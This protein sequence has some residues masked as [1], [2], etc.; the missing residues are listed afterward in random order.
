MS[1]FAAVVLAAGASSRLGQPKQLLLYRGEPLIRRTARL[2]SE[3][4]AAWVW[5]VVPP[6][7]PAVREA[8][9]GLPA[10]TP[11]ENPSPAEGMGSSLRLVM[12]AVLPAQPERVLLMV[13]DQPLLEA[14]DYQALLAEP[15]SGGISAAFYNGHRGVPAVFDRRYFSSLAKAEGDQGARALLQGPGVA[16]VPMPQAAADVDT[17]ENL[18]L[19]SN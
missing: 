1:P 11:V 18:N 17:P 6:G 13:C 19:L 15:S 12:A 14:A 2:A 9:A 7:L 16:T 8:L 3:A 10:V 5:V 4:G